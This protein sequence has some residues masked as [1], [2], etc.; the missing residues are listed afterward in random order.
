MQV[1][2]PTNP[3]HTNAAQPHD[4]PYS[5][6][7]LTRLS[8]VGRSFLF[9]ST[10]GCREVLHSIPTSRIKRLS[11]YSCSRTEVQLADKI[12]E[13]GNMQDQSAWHTTEPCV[14]HSCYFQ[15]RISRA[16]R[17]P[18][19]QSQCAL[20]GSL[21]LTIS[22]LCLQRALFECLKVRARKT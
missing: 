1:A 14:G 21:S 4:L 10:P 5:T 18:L 13:A 3:Y 22:D 6:C 17:M 16:V 8:C 11:S 15:P 9:S 20:V 12:F 7:Q 2:A 19:T